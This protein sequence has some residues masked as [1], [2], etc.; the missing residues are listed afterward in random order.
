MPLR[1]LPFATL[2]AA[3]CSPSGG[4]ED[5][6]AVETAPARAPVV[7]AESRGDGDCSYLWNGKAVTAQGIV[8]KSVAAISR[9]IDDVGGIENITE[10]NMLVIRLEGAANLPYA[11]TGPALRQLERAGLVRIV[12]KPDGTAGQS[13]NFLLE[14]ETAGPFAIIRLSKDGMSWDGRPIDQAGLRERVRAE[15]LNRPPVVP[16]VAPAEDSSFLALHDSTATISQA[17][18]VAILSGCAGTSGP[19]REAEPVC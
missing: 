5:Q 19:V 12:L 6:A 4:G 13:A 2:L 9:A 15:A 17:G 7:R 11:C 18:M 16:V 14:P 3:S 1:W 8:D 10:Q